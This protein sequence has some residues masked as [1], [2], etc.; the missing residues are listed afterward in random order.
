[1]QHVEIDVLA[2]LALEGFVQVAGDVLWRDAFAPVV[3]M[4]AL[5][6]DHDFLAHA[7]AVDPLAEH[8]LAGATAIAV[9][10]V[11]GA[12]AVFEHGIEQGKAARHVVFGE[13]DRALHEPGDR[14]V[15]AGNG[16]VFHGHAGIAPVGEG[17]CA[18]P[19]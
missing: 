8:A 17:L 9:G 16:S 19:D 15:D 11:E 14:L 5:A 4:G 6:E 2:A 18:L 3:G 7:A 13:G 12:A 10:G 1:M